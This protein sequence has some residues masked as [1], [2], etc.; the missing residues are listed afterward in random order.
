MEQVLKI[1][2]IP[3]L[4][5]FFIVPRWLWGKKRKAVEEAEAG[6]EKEEE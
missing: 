5:V 2:A 1:I 4:A 3:I 6:R